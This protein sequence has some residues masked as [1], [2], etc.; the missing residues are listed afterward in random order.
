MSK[1][2]SRHKWVRLSL[3]GVRS[4]LKTIDDVKRLPH[5][6]LDGLATAIC[7]TRPYPPKFG[8]LITDVKS[9]I[10]ALDGW[11]AHYKN[12]PAF[13]RFLRQVI[14]EL[15][16]RRG[17]VI[18]RMK[19]ER[20]AMRWAKVYFDND[21]TLQCSE[22]QKPSEAEPAVFFR[23]VLPGP[24]GSRKHLDAMLILG[25]GVLMEFLNEDRRRGFEWT[26]EKDR[27]KK[28]NVHASELMAKVLDE[29]WTDDPRIEKSIAG[30]RMRSSINSQHK[31]AVDNLPSLP[32][33]GFLEFLKGAEGGTHAWLPARSSRA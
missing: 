1:R 12:D 31:R 5:A 27:K 25:M 8:D 16:A 2:S 20:P 22:L 11:T 13:R 6:I 21:G 30:T 24:V 14:D 28:T 10:N 17:R 26:V 4:R 15:E 19:M 18:V 29:L 23:R 7:L 32:K 3:E 33:A 9:A